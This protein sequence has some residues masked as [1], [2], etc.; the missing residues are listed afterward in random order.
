MLVMSL[1]SLSWIRAQEPA[2]DADANQGESKAKPAE[3]PGAAAAKTGES[4]EGEEGA[5]QGIDG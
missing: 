2:P 3:K 5:V 4:S 1:V